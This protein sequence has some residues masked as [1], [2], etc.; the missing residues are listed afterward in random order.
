MQ[1][2]THPVIISFLLASE[3]L[4]PFGTSRSR[5]SIKACKEGDVYESEMETIGCK[6]LSSQAP[7]S[8]PLCSISLLM[9]PK[10]I[11]FRFFSHSKYDTVTPPCMPLN[12]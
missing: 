3:N 12:G 9:R 10:R 5:A 1:N 8:L 11:W 4:K 2:I 7:T 6:K